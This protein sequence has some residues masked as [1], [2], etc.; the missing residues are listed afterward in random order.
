MRS[1]IYAYLSQTE[2]A[3]SQVERRQ[4]ALL[5]WTRHSQFNVNPMGKIVFGI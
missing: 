4:R 3:E 2:L 5:H 1:H